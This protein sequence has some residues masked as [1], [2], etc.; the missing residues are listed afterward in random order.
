M[1][2]A[3]FIFSLLFHVS[4]A[5]YRQW[6]PDTNFNN[7]S[8]WD[9]GKIP[10][11][12]DRILFL[13]DKLSVF[14]Q[15]PLDLM[16]MYAP[17]DGEFILSHSAGFAASDGQ[18]EPGCERGEDITFKDPDQ[19]KWYDPKYWQTTL[20]MS[21][22]E[23]NKYIFTLDEESVP[24]QYDDVVFQPGTSFRVDL[25][26]DAQNINVKTI[27]LMNMK[28]AS[29]ADFDNY[30][31]SYT[32]KLQFYGNASIAVTNTKCEDKS[33]CDC[34]NSDNHRRICSNLQQELRSHCTELD[35]TNPL[36][37]QG[38]CCEICGAI[39]Y[40]TYDD[41]FDLELYREQLINSFFGLGDNEGVQISMTKIYK[42]NFSKQTIPND[43]VSHIQIVL[44]DNATKLTTGTLAA[45]LAEE[46]MADITSQGDAFGIVSA[47]LKKSTNIEEQEGR[48]ISA[49]KITGIV[50]GVLIA[51]L[52]TGSLTFFF[53][54][55]RIR[56]KIPLP[57]IN[58]KNYF[59]C[60]VA[61]TV[62][63]GFSNPVYDPQV[64]LSPDSC[65]HYP[66]EHAINIVPHQAGTSIITPPF[67]GH[68]FG[69]QEC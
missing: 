28:F 4:G 3:N 64:N 31:Q 14:V 30:K 51:A 59:N 54:S 45:R 44:I 11:K 42:E 69:E 41:Q 27:S 12:N 56:V 9:K 58:F 60:D 16:E 35:C 38:H 17:L 66:G 21:E 26:S 6:I 65:G 2:S 7:A 53:I 68:D 24:C 47:E 67:D 36:K 55:G 57:L 48:N 15:T 37:P 46:I 39:I 10:C 40:L 1:W 63:K 8:N 5:L 50:V 29:S 62:D 34:G 18:S 33:G 52:L 43:A 25:D 22:Q 61:E 23:K 32:G 49:G 20:S 19:Y 13:R